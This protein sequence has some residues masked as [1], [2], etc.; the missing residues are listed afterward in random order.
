[1][2][3]GRDETKRPEEAAGITWLHHGAG[4]PA[5]A[6]TPVNVEAAKFWR[7]RGD[8]KTYRPGF[9]TPGGVYVEQLSID[10]HLY[11]ITSQG[12]GVSVIHQSSCP[13]QK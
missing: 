13:C 4:R 5:D 11:L 8:V 10:G 3:H 6:L 12:Y 7:V 2:M 1:M 9:C